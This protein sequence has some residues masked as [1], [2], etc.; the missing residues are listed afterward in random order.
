MRTVRRSKQQQSLCKAVNNTGFAA[1]I[2]T[3]NTMDAYFGSLP[4]TVLKMCGA[5]W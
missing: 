1:R 4:A 5:R 3:V 2:E